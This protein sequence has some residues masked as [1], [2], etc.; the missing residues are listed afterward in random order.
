[1]AKYDEQFKL[2]IVRQYLDGQGGY[3]TVANQ[4]G[5][6]HGMVRRW[7]KWF[8]TYGADAFK[9]KFTHYSAEFKLSVLRHLWENELSYGQAAVHFNIRSPGALGIWERSYRSGGLKA[10]RARP[11]GRPKAMA[12]PTTKPEQLPDPGLRSRD[13]LLAELDHLRMENAYLKKLQALV[14]ARPQQVQPKKHK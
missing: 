1:M 10:L 12:G 8:E 7:V 9:K 3:K 11:K 4:H 13:E 2:A 14:Q 5:L 6:C